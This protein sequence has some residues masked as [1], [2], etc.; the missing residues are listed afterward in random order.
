M[1]KYERENKILKKSNK[2][3][4]LKSKL[5]FLFE[6]SD[7]GFESLILESFNNSSHFI[8]SIVQTRNYYTHGDK[9]TKYPRLMTD[10]NDLYKANMILQKLL[11]YYLFKE[12]EMEYSFNKY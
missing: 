4:F 6:N 5:K 1:R 8:D 2:E 3:S 11:H 7:S 9:K 12:L 10:Y